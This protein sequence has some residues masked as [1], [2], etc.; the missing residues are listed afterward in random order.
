MGEDKGNI[1]ISGTA[2]PFSALRYE[3][4]I[5]TDKEKFI[6]VDLVVL[7]VIILINN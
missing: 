6:F 5:C 7:R 2:P 3:I 1:H 4:A